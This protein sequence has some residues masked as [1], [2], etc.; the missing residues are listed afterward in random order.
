M[1]RL[2]CLYFLLSCPSLVFAQA[3][4]IRAGS[5]EIGGFMGSSYGVDS[6]RVM[7]GGNVSYGVTK[8]ILAYVEYSYFPAIQRQIN[9]I[10]GGTTEPYKALYSVPISDFHAGVHIRITHGGWRFVPYGVIGVGGLIRSDFSYAIKYQNP[11]GIF[12][13]QVPVPGDTVAA[14][15]AGGGVRYYL[16]RQARY[17]LRVEAKIYKPYG[18]KATGYTDP[19][20]KAE[21]GFFIQLH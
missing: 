18:D 13:V 1:H 8:P 17:G 3:P 10:I 7:G 19:F 20:L 14:L 5:F 6:F 9:G 16:G 12:S 2:P 11:N 21:I 4:V 15:N